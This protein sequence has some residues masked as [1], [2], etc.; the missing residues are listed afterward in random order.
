[1]SST[2]LIVGAGQ[3]GAQAVDTLRR[4]GFEGR[5]VLI[6]DEPHLPYQR[7]PLS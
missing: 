3:A 4:E 5:L 6:G 1:M 7:P 2:I